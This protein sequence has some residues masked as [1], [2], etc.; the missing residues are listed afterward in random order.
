MVTAYFSVHP[1]LINGF[2]VFKCDTNSG[3]KVGD[4]G[5]IIVDANGLVIGSGSG[6]HNILP[7]GSNQFCIACSMDSLV[8]KG[9]ELIVD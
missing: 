4:S 6:G 7:D 3:Y 5:S 9:F 1:H 2:M 8:G